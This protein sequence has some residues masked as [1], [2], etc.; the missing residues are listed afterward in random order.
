MVRHAAHPTAIPAALLREYTEVLLVE[1][2]RSEI[3]AQVP[4]PAACRRATAWFDETIMAPALRSIVG[5]PV[6]LQD[7]ESLSNA[8]S[9]AWLQGI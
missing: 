1:W 7:L 6:P 5:D 4:E 2:Y 8:K 3:G 9:A